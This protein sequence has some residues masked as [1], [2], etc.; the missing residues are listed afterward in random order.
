MKD[1]DLQVEFQFSFM[2]Y[3]IYL[4]STYPEPGTDFSHPI[5]GKLK[6]TAESATEVLNRATEARNRAGT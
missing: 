1:A 6:L 2:F 4:F 3:N 5:D